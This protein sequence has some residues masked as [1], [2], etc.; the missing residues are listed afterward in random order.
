M[1]TPKTLKF[2][3]I[4]AAIG[5]Q[6]AEELMLLVYGPKL[7]AT[8]SYKAQAINYEKGL[9]MANSNWKD[10]DDPSGKRWSKSYPAIRKF[11]S[12]NPRQNNA[13][14]RWC[15]EKLA[16]IGEREPIAPRIKRTYTRR[17]RQHAQAV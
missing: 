5:Q 17:S 16:E 3:S 4:I 2:D 12:E 1:R 11:F 7:V 14:A 13:F 15:E 6:R 10:P 8:P 9:A